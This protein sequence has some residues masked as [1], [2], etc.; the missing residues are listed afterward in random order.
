[1]RKSL[2][3]AIIAG[4]IVLAAACGT[5]PEENAFTVTIAGDTSFTIE[6]EAIFGVSVTQGREYW[7]IFLSRGTFGGL[8]YD[9]IAIGRHESATPIGEGAHAIAD[10]DSEELDPE[11]I[12]AVYVLRRSA[13][14]SIASYGSDTGTITITSASNDM[15]RGEFSFEADF[16]LAVGSFGGIE[17]LTISGSFTAIRGDVPSVTS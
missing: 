9:A 4:S 7:V 10:A 2:T 8:D 1:M 6:G 16:E 13:D 17:D 5:D 14:G 12:D 3:T 11:D 15:I